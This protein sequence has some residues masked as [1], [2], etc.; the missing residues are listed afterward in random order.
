MNHKINAPQFIKGFMYLSIRSFNFSNIGID[1]VCLPLIKRIIILFSIITPVTMTEL[2]VRVLI[3]EFSRKL[4]S[5]TL[6]MISA[7]KAI[8]INRAKI[9]M[10]SLRILSPI[11][12]KPKSF[13][14]LKMK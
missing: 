1:C 12:L 5:F 8:I 7:I 4:E 13:L 11:C 6:P 10:N 2:K 14:I 3:V 9:V